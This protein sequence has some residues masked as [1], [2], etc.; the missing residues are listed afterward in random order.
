VVWSLPIYLKWVDLWPSWA[1]LLLFNQFGRYLI[2]SICF[3][4]YQFTYCQFYV[5]TI[6]RFNIWFCCLSAFLH[7]HCQFKRLLITFR[8]TSQDCLF[9]AYYVNFLI[10]I[11]NV[12]SFN[13]F[14]VL[15][16]YSTNTFVS[17]L[18]QAISIRFSFDLNNTS[19]FVC[20]MCFIF[21]PFILVR[22]VWFFG[23]SFC[24]ELRTAIF[25][26]ITLLVVVSSLCNF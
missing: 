7:C 13:P 22:F 26:V 19:F 5:Y 24:C 2:T 18:L 11:S 17:L 14:L 9:I 16:T 10:S 25:R 20:F 1:P 12:C 15:F 6:W 4:L 23:Q 3:S 8:P 21:Y